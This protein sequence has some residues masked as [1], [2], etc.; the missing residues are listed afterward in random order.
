[1]LDPTPVFDDIETKVREIVGPIQVF[2][3]EVPEDADIPVSNGKP[4][5]FVAVFPGGP[6]RAARGHHIANSRWD[7]TI[8]FWTILVS[9]PRADIARKYKGMLID[10]LTGYRPVDSGELVLA[11]GNTPFRAS[12]E[13]R[14]TQYLDEVQFSV[15][16]NL[17]S[18]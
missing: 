1:M 7:T 2:V 10:G 16:S 3:A 18:E 9:A 14:P 4:Q 17:K 5:P 6:I 11:G 13:V 12:N 15:R 8:L